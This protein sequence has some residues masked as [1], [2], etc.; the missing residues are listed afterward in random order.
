MICPMNKK[1]EGFSVV[2]AASILGVTTKTIYRWIKA[3]KITYRE[4][5]GTR[6]KEF[7]ILKIPGQDSETE[8]KNTE[9]LDMGLDKAL[10]II[11]KLQQEKALLTAQVAAAHVTIQNLEG[12]IKLLQAPK[13]PWWKF[14]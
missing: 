11:D 8:A 13:K 5:E 2:Q 3:K 4:V 10:D 14:W 6:G 9:R 12:Q 7:R 1:S